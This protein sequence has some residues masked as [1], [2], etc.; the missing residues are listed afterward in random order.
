MRA[1]IAE[2]DV[3]VATLPQDTPTL[4][5]AQSA[6]HVFHVPQVLCRL[7]DSERQEIYQKLVELV[8][9]PAVVRDVGVCSR[10]WVLEKLAG[11][12]V[13]NRYLESYARIGSASA[14]SR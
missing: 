2:A 6:Q 12:V 9:S 5:A 4:L 13:V 1:G 11:D 8:Q 3:F 10:Q 7:N 14:A